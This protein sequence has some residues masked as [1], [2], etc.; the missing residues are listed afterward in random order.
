MAQR[1]KRNAALTAL[2]RIRLSSRRRNSSASTSNTVPATPPE[3]HH[4]ERPPPMTV[5]SPP[6]S[7]PTEPIQE[8]IQADPDE[9][10]TE[11]DVDTQPQETS[12]IGR[13]RFEQTAQETP[14]Q[15]PA[16]TS[17]TYIQRRLALMI[18]IPE[19]DNNTDRLHHIVTEVNTFLKAA[20]KTHAY[21]RLRRFDDITPPD[22]KDRKNWRTKMNFD[23][24]ADFKEYIQGYYPFTPPRGGQYRFRLNTVLESSLPVA[25]FL[26]NVTH[27]WG[28]KDSR[29]ISDLKSQR[30]WDP[31]KIGYLMRAPRYITYSN[32]LV[33]ALEKEANVNS[34][35]SKVYFGTSWSTI[36]S[37]AGGYDKDTSVQAVMIETNKVSQETAVALLKRWYPLDPN[38]RSAPPFP[39]NFRFVMNRD[40]VRVKG[41]PVALANLSILM[42]RQGIF[43]QDTRG[44]Q[45]FCIQDLNMPYKGNDSMTVREKLLQTKVRTLSEELKGSPLFLA[46]ATAINNR[47]STRS[48]W[49]T[50]HKKVAT[51]AIS[52][53]RNLPIFI[54]TEWQVQ[55]DYICYAQF[56]NPSD[57][58]DKKNRVANNED[59]DE[60]RMAA[61]VH[62]LDLKKASPEVSIIESEDAESMTSKAQREMRRMMENDEETVMTISQRKIV[63]PRPAAIV[64]NDEASQGAISGF[65]GASSKSSMLRAKMR[66][67]FDTKIAEQ[68][69]VVKKMQQDKKD[70]DIQQQELAQQV[71]KLQEALAQLTTPSTDTPAM[72]QNE[73]MEDVFHDP[74]WD[75]ELN[76]EADF[77]TTTADADYA[78]MIANIENRIIKNLDHAPTKEELV[79]ISIEAQKLATEFDATTDLAITT[80]LP[81]SFSDDSQQSVKMSPSRTKNVSR[82]RMADSDESSE[83]DIQMTTSDTSQSLK[84]IAGTPS[85]DTDEDTTKFIASASTT[86]KKKTST[87]G[88]RPPPRNV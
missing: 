47:T 35:A 72:A 87:T 49:F 3:R 19:V 20:R 78:D 65:S 40:N 88:G 55:P 46:V 53:V 34:T 26:E 60:I 8:E 63:N 18:S 32:E 10:E 14:T 85:D 25:T 52:V 12:R 86:P 6:D 29:S 48:V 2:E 62:T 50:F 79:N 43:N 22:S 69:E 17:K 80:P 44:E 76:M 51:E 45:T 15:E 16:S 23:S 1:P 27:D 38:R 7:P 11:M 37:P 57:K 9:G 68:Q 39:G 5:P 83:S 59:T 54:Q 64:I 30:I 84:R 70:Q 13:V 61:E 21:F 73:S 75:T 28:Q 58:W 36:P 31:V 4:S 66:H 71:A 74:A 81:A 33:D 67:E 24:S 77:D 42:E 56:L 82:L 41:N